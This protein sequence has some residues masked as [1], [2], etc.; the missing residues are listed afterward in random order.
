M[1]GNPADN[2]RVLQDRRN[3]EVVIKDGAIVKFDEA[4]RIARPFDRAIIYST[5]DLTWDVVYGDGQ[6]AGEALLDALF[7]AD[8]G[9]DVALALRKPEQAAAD[10]AAEQIS[11]A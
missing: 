5:G 1:S 9:R 10:A 4:K 7:S 3:I 11:A 8:E 2:I 6:P